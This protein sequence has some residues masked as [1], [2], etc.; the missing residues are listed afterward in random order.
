MEEKPIDDVAP[1]DGAEEKEPG[2]LP[3]INW[4]ARIRNK[5]WWLAVIPAVLLLVQQVLVMFG[6]TWDYTPL[7]TQLSGLVCALFAVLALCGVVADP[8]T[9][10]LSDSSRALGYERPAPNAWDDEMA[11]AMTDELPGDCDGDR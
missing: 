1:G 9:N 4:A 6:V 11:Y 3:Q 8:T 10:G 5:W 2:A 7:E